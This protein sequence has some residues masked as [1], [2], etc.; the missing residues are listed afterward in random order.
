MAITDIPEHEAT[1]NDWGIRNLTIDEFRKRMREIRLVLTDNDGVLTDTGVY[2]SER[3]EELKRYSIRDGMG[4]ERLRNIGIDTGIITGERS[5]NLR[6]RARKLQIPY[7]YLGIADKGAQLES[8]LNQT[9]LRLSQIAFIGDDV[10]DLGLMEIIR[11]HGLIASPF[12]G[13]PE[14]RKMAHYVCRTSG[15]HGAFRDF[16]ELIISGNTKQ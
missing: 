4:V 16:A 1:G 2:Y 7:L 6:K 5:E 3:G 11:D 14:V 8:I 13:M 15:G 9:G 10:N 12:D